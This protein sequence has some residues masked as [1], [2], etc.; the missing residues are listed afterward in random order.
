M[1]FNCHEE[2]LECHSCPVEE[3]LQEELL[4][5]LQAA[6]DT[7]LVGATAATGQA[8][9]TAVLLR[10]RDVDVTAAVHQQISPL[11]NVTQFICDEVFPLNGVTAL[12]A[13][14]TTIA[15]IKLY[16]PWDGLIV[17]LDLEEI[18]ISHCPFFLLEGAGEEVDQREPEDQGEHPPLPQEPAPHH[19]RQV[20]HPG[21]ERG[22]TGAPAAWPLHGRQPHGSR[23]AP[24]PRPSAQPAPVSH[25]K[26]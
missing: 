13:G 3:A 1:I 24:A 11:T 9:V 8:A 14:P 18:P 5:G 19:S 12:V 4:V 6:G 16:F 15:Q 25:L 17:I 7:V 2:V 20:H 21:A 10:A 26:Y 22:R 23:R